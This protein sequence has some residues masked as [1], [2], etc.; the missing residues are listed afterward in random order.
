MNIMIRNA[1]PSTTPCNDT[2]F[3]PLELSSLTIQKNKHLVFMVMSHLSG[4]AYIATHLPKDAN[5]VGLEY[6][7]NGTPLQISEIYENLPWSEIEW[8]DENG[9]FSFKEAPSFQEMTDFL[10]KLKGS[11]RETHV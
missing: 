3:Y 9:I 7:V 11:F 2:I 8:K 10:T 5:R 6:H 1:L 4:Q